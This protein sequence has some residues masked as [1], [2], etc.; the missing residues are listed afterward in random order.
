MGRTHIFGWVGPNRFRNDR[1]PPPKQNIYY[2]VSFITGIRY[3]LL[4]INE[5]LTRAK[6][7]KRKQE[8]EESIDAIPSRFNG[9]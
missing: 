4:S 7:A 8:V 5:N 6:N 2:N 3:T 1:G 9:A